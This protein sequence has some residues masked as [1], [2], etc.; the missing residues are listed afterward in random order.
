[1]T[2]PPK[3]WGEGNFLPAFLFFS[4]S[5]S[6]NLVIYDALTGTSKLKAECSSGIERRICFLHFPPPFFPGSFFP[7]FSCAFFLVDLLFLLEILKKEMEDYIEKRYIPGLRYHPSESINLMKD[8]FYR[9]APD[10]NQSS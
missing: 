2:V 9:K 10:L 7:S 8:A 6:T 3:F 5:W 4:L 1:M